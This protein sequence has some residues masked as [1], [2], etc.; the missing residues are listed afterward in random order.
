MTVR[1]VSSG[2]TQWSALPRPVKATVIA[3]SACCAAAGVLVASVATGPHAVAPLPPLTVSQQ[4]EIPEGQDS[5][6]VDPARVPPLPLL[7]GA[8][9]QY[10]APADLPDGAGVFVY[11]Q[12]PQGENEVVS[13][14]RRQLPATGWQVLEEAPAPGQGYQLLVVSP[15]GEMGQLTV[16]A[17]PPGVPGQRSQ[18]SGTLE[19]PRAGKPG[20]R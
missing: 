10:I 5:R 9:Q 20:G 16:S 17:L 8:V 14:L 18:V 3:I 11:A 4:W 1:V 15:D 7:E 19:R 2:S 12:F 6:Q 13:H